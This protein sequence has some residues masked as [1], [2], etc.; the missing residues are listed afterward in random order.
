MSLR[1]AKPTC[2]PA[3]GLKLPN[4]GTPIP[5]ELIEQDIGLLASLPGNRP[6]I[7]P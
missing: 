6:T 5:N 3:A 2:N 7:S 4:V 1:I